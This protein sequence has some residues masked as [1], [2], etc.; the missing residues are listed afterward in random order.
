MPDK[1][2]DCKAVKITLDITGVIF[3]FTAIQTFT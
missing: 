2:I 3:N 1:N